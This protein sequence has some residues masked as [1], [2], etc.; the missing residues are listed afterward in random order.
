MNH[1]TILY[2]I[3][4]T[5]YGKIE[6]TLSKYEDTE[7]KGDRAGK[8]EGTGGLCG[9]TGKEKQHQAL[10]AGRL[11]RHGDTQKTEM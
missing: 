7:G 9:G 6:N 4:S 3:F 8:D 10:V 1:F 11:K 2:P 5:A